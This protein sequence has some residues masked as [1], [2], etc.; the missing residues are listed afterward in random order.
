MTF[1]PRSEILTFEEIVR[2]ATVAHELGVDSMRI[3]GGE[4][5]VR[6]DLA[7]L[8]KR[9]GSLGRIDLSLTTNGMFLAPVATELADAGLSRVNISC[10]SL[11]P[12]RFAAMRRRGDLD[13][14]LAAMDA[15][16][17]AGLRPLKVNVVLMAGVNDDEIVDFG[18]FARSTGRIVRFI[19]FMPLDADGSWGRDQ[20][21]SGDR[22]L[23]EI[24]AAWPIEP[25]VSTVSDPAPAERYRFV[26]GGGEIGVISSVSRPFCG[27]CD[28]LRLT[29]D[30][31]IRNCLFSDDEVSVRDLMRQ[32]GSDADI[33]L[34][35]RTAVWAK[36]SGHGIND[37]DFEAPLRSMSMIGG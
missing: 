22:V 30:G 3:T 35:L 7:S 1:L 4:P 6:K 12:E 37:D 26:D 18:A 33:A 14:V 10:D 11:R 27:T 17:A 34:A 36:A 13:R 24:G 23:E 20:M 15:A 19:E 5:L 25:I 16:E 21:V 2:V 9:L 31:S 29:A 28:R 32:G 8:V